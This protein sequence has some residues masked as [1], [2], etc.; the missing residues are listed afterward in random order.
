MAQ[1]VPFDLDVDV[2]EATA[3]VDRLRAAIAEN[4]SENVERT[5]LRQAKEFIKSMRET[6]KVAYERVLSGRA[7]Y[8]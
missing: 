5:A 4:N 2:D 6:V 7:E 3:V 8:D 1:M